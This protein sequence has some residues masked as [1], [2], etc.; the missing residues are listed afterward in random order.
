MAF[1]QKW[2]GSGGLRR[3]LPNILENRQK[4]HEMRSVLGI[5]TSDIAPGQGITS[6][7]DEE[8]VAIYNDNDNFIVLRNVCKHLA[9]QTEWNVSDKTWDCPCHGSRYKANGEVI[10]G[11][12]RK[13]LDKLDYSL[14]NE[15]IKLA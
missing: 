10:H 12:A 8:Y 1:L 3:F 14:E 7:I 9:C 11:P 5:K 6:K 13:S 4:A 15:E 2:T